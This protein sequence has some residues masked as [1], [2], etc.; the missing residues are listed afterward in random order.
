MST[1]GKGIDFSAT[2]DG[3]GTDTSELF[4]DYEE[5]TWTPTF[6]NYGGTDQNPNGYYTKIGNLVT[7]GCRIGT[8]GTSDGSVA[9]ISGLPYTVRASTED[10]AIGGVFVSYTT[11]VAAQRWYAVNN[12]VTVKGADGTGNDIN[13]NDFG[14]SKDVRCVIIYLT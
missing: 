13:Y 6:A 5:G 10:G 9:T 1:S 11:G 4:D 2:G 3:A 12:T 7:A 14:A 8:D